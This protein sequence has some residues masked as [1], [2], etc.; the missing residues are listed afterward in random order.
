MISGVADTHPLIWYA[1]GQLNRIGRSAR[2]IFEA[3]DRKDGSGMVYVPAIVLHEVS[4]LLIGEK[5]ELAEPFPYWVR[6]LEKHGF[7]VIVDVGP[8]MIIPADSF[9]GIA[10]PFDRLIMGCAALLEQPFLTRDE[11]ITV[12]NNV[13]V[14]WE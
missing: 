1:T 4:S 11:R 8:A 5:I 2:R 12:S 10:D 14:I 6:A 13:A 7:F 9:R 3:A